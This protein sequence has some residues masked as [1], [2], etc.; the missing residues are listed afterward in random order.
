MPQFWLFSR[1]FLFE[2]LVQHLRSLSAL[3]T[4]FDVLPPLFGYGCDING[5]WN[6]V[7]LLGQNISSEVYVTNILLQP[8]CFDWKIK[9]W[10][11]KQIFALRCKLLWS[12]SVKQYI[13]KRSNQINQRCI[14]SLNLPPNKLYVEEFLWEFKAIEKHLELLLSAQ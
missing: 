12:L 9:S 6:P 11:F 10:H 3:N 13:Y 4:I 8:L 1:Q 14:E 7:V 2:G 5:L